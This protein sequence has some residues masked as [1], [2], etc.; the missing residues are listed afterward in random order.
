MVFTLSLGGAIG[1]LAVKYED[2]ISVCATAI[3]GAFSQL[4]IF[5]SFGFEFTKNL[6]GIPPK[7]CTDWP[8][9]VTLVLFILYGVG[10]V[11]NQF[12]MAKIAKKLEEEPEYE[13][14]GKYERTLVKITK[15]FA[16]L[17]S[18]NDLVKEQGK[19]HTQEELK[20]LMSKNMAIVL[21]LGT[22]ASD[23]G[24]VVLSLSM[25]SAIVEGFAGG[26]FVFE[27][28]ALN[29]LAL[30][31]GVVGFLTILLVAFAL[32]TKVISDADKKA[33]RMNLFL[34]LAAFIMPFVAACAIVAGVM[35]P[36]TAV[37][38]PQLKAYFVEGIS[39]DQKEALEDKKK[40]AATWGAPTTWDG[41]FDQSIDFLTL[42]VFKEWRL[43][44]MLRSIDMDGEPRL[45]GGKVVNLTDASVST[46]L[47]VIVAGPARARVRD[48]DGLEQKFTYGP[49]NRKQQLVNVFDQL[50]LAV[51]AKQ[52]EDKTVT[53]YEIRRT[54][55]SYNPTN[56]PKTDGQIVK[57]GVGEANVVFDNVK[58]DKGETVVA[59]WRLGR[60]VEELS[61][62]DRTCGIVYDGSLV[63]VRE[64][65]EG[66]REVSVP[67]FREDR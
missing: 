10:G 62:T 58:V 14:E 46:L 51:V 4:Q 13:G 39:L 55:R 41:K 20:E 18:L 19:P 67:P 66:M 48:G 43:D 60:V 36:G 32:K 12:N 29:F 54:K 3:M 7:G 8:C 28:R 63:L 16:I 61:S 34:F 44:G 25:F 17:F 24:L 9:Q 11:K 31:L 21:Q 5:C 64:T 52:N 37:E 57:D 45:L 2:I 1:K 40:A 49:Q 56:L 33:S 23:I 42:P 50:V 15:T 65:G 38:V 30:A 26:A 27:L 35:L 59:Y 22:I 53:T 6:A 47:N